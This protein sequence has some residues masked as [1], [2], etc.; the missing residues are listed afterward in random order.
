MASC[1]DVPEYLREDSNHY[2]H[3]PI[4]DGGGE[5]DC[6]QHCDSCGAFLENP[7]T[8]DGVAY[9]ADSLAKPLPKPD[10]RN[11]YGRLVSDVRA[12]WADCY[13]AELADLAKATESSHAA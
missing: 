5:A 4:G 6:P 13:K 12:D 2:P 9:V 8:P 7:L 1:E 3:G 11:V 10:A